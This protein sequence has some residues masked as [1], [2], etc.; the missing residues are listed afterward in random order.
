MLFSFE[1]RF[2][3]FLL[4]VSAMDYTL[5]NR[6]CTDGNIVQPEGNAPI[7][8]RDFMP[9]KIPIPTGSCGDIPYKLGVSTIEG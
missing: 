8:L 3:L 9:P 1:R 7:W 6:A 2:L 4:E 5:S